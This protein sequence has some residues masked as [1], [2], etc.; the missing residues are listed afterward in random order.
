MSGNAYVGTW[1][2]VAI[3]DYNP[4]NNALTSILN[5]TDTSSIVCNRLF[6]GAG[7]TWNYNQG[8]ATL[9]T[10]GGTD[11]A[12]VTT[13]LL[14][15]GSINGVGQLTLN[16]S[17][18]ISNAGETFIGDWGNGTVTLNDNARLNAA[19]GY[20]SYLGGYYGNGTLVVNGGEADFGPGLHQGAYAYD[21][22]T[23]P[24]IHPTGTMNINGGTVTTV[25]HWV[26]LDGGIGVV[27]IAAGG[28]L[29][30]GW[31]FMDVGECDDGTPL[32]GRRHRHR[33]HQRHRAVQNRRGLEPADHR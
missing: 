23:N 31:W 5:M 2:D 6:V 12:H 30:Y 11:T 29:K 26:G 21:D 24:V 1:Y 10:L 22:G 17:T 4:D 14:Q 8:V 3:G 19:G 27:N 9:G 18:Y 28:T 33:Q 7:P 32:T 13:N 20:G 16:A 15:V 25:G